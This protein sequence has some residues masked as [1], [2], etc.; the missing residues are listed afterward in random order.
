[1]LVPVE[2]FDRMITT[3]KQNVTVPVHI[4]YKKAVAIV[5]QRFIT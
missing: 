2:I 3:F 5:I 1:M 4:L